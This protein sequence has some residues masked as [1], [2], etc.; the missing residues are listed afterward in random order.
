[1]SVKPLSARKQ[2]HIIKLAWVGN[3]VYANRSQ[4]Y[5][6]LLSFA[7]QHEDYLCGARLSIHS[8]AIQILCWSIQ[9]H[10]FNL[11]DC[12]YCMPLLARLDTP[13]STKCDF[14]GTMRRKHFWYSPRMPEGQL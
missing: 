9:P 3:A 7:K 11:R 12:G 4:V 1:M 10:L 5:E 8:D 2:D 6:D 14:L 13:I